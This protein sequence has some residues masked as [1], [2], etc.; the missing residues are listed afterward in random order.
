MAETKE[1]LQRC[2][3]AVFPA[4]PH[5]EI[6]NASPAT[7]AAWDSVAGVTLFAVV[8]EEFAL[9]IDVQEM[10]DLLSFASLLRYLEKQPLQNGT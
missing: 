4:L 9:E 5:G 3:S 1:R 7:I 6:V 10:K 2:F 8:E